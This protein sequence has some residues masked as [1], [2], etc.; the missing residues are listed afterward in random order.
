MLLC[1]FLTA[2]GETVNHL[3]GGMMPDEMLPKEFFTV[4]DDGTKT[5]THLDDAGKLVSKTFEYS[6]GRINHCTYDENEN[7]ISE[8][9]T[10]P[11]GSSYEYEYDANGNIVE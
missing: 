7:R 2:C 4:S 11:D 9:G 3:A 6:D 5:T 1:F 8:T 10:S